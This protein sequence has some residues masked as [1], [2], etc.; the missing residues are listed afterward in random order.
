MSTM[1]THVAEFW[2]AAVRAGAAAPGPLVVG[3]SGGPDSLALLHLLR[4]LAPE[5][6]VQLHVAHLDHGWRGAAG[7]ADA[8]FVAATAAAWDVP[9]TCA[10]W[11]V[12]AYAAAARLSPEDAAR[13]VR[14]AFLARVAATTGAA[15][16]AVGHNA[17]DQVETV[18]THWLRGA[19]LRGLAG[20]APW[21]PLPQFDFGFWILDFGVAAPLE[22]LSAT[23]EEQVG[24]APAADP[25]SKIQNPKSVWLLR[26]LLGVWRTEIAAYCA[27]EGLAPREDATNADPTYRRN[28]LR[29]TLIPLLERE[30]PGLA[31]RLW[32]NA[33]MFRDEDTALEA[34][35]D[36]A[37][38]TLAEVQAQAVVL[39]LAA[40]G[41]LPPALQRRALRRAAQL[42][43]GDLQ[44]L[45]AVH[46]RE[47]LVLLG[48]AGQTGAALDWP[49]GLRVRRERAHAVVEQA[50]RPAAD[51][52]WPCLAPGDL[53]HLPD[54]GAVRL[55]G[56]TLEIALRPGPATTGDQPREFG[57]WRAGFDA[58]GLPGAAEGRLVLRTRQP[59]DRIRP[60]GAGGHSRKLQDVLVDAGVPQH[61]RDSLAL[62][63]CADGTILWIPGPGGRRGDLAPITP[64]TRQI[65]VFTFSPE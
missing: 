17:D 30:Q 58:A 40:F 65:Q 2:T 45:A 39:G 31:R 46:I 14:Y 25:K 32:D 7:R 33:A 64:N 35:L 22:S 26:P 53:W 44:G 50:T 42:V 37:W 29:Q 21:A 49:G 52:R 34:G 18:V 43:A 15:A 56:W 16:V 57:A 60:F 9:C 59:G 12:P 28:H 23:G 55:P 10:A 4:R 63:A 62:L 11:D 5:W 3:V 54:A 27:Q 36:Q 48:P 24:P 38:P 20:M 6:G 8:A 1:L 41:A 47:A 61:L 51:R 19:G 13:R